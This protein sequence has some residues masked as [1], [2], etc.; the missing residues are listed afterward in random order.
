MPNNPERYEPIV[1]ALAD[2]V[3]KFYT[4]IV[5]ARKGALRYAPGKRADARERGVQHEPEREKDEP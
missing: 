4:Q 1:G 5:A 3:G 2:V